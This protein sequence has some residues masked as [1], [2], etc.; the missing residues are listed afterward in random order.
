MQKSSYRL[1][2]K[3]SSQRTKLPQREVWETSEAAFWPLEGAGM[4]RKKY[5]WVIRQKA[6]ECREGCCQ[7]QFGLMA[8]IDT[9]EKPVGKRQFCAE[10]RDANEPGRQEATQ[11]STST[12]SLSHHSLKQDDFIVDKANRAETACLGKQLDVKMLRELPQYFTV[13]SPDC[14][15]IFPPFS[16]A[17]RKKSSITHEFCS[18]MMSQKAYILK[19]AFN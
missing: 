18:K 11:Q 10:D 9:Q 8:F 2:E 17:A 6:N 12:G 16:T 4:Q 3:D 19:I 5:G 14:Q 15:I 1:S 13:T 7:G